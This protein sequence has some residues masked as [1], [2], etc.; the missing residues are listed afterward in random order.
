MAIYVNLF[1]KSSA[2]ALFYSDIV[3]A[4]CR[5]RKKFLDIRRWVILL[6]PLTTGYEI[7]FLLTLSSEHQNPFQRRRRHEKKFSSYRCVY[8]YICPHSLSGAKLY[9]RKKK[10]KIIKRGNCQKY[11]L[12][13]IFSF[14]FLSL[15]SFSHGDGEFS[16]SYSLLFGRWCEWWLYARNGIKRWQK[17]NKQEESSSFI[18]VERIFEE[19]GRRSGDWR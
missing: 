15:S 4:H 5:V 6:H 16:S 8:V 10:K 14:V 17:E 7:H 13:S 12:C 11:D 1:S 9:K 18:L 19:R 2:T 3:S